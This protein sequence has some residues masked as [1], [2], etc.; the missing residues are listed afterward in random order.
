MNTPLI[1]GVI[2]GAVGLVAGI[3]MVRRLRRIKKY[4]RTVRAHLGVRDKGY[5]DGV[6]ALEYYNMNLP[7]SSAARAMVAARCGH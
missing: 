4:E 3:M 6:I 5:Y 1:Y 2:V 7:A